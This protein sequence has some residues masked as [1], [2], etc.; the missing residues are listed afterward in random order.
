MHGSALENADGEARRVLC[1]VRCFGD[2]LLLHCFGGAKDEDVVQD[3]LTFFLF[4]FWQVGGVFFV[5][6]ALDQVCQE[7]RRGNA[8]QTFERLARA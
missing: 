5:W 3:E 2:T 4:S 8:K 1:D 7:R 6:F